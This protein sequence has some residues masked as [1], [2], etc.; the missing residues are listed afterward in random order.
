MIVDDPVRMCQIIRPAFTIPI[1]DYAKNEETYLRW[2][3]R[4]HHEH[5]IKSYLMRSGELI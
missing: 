5:R 4:Q 3:L 2:E 1:A